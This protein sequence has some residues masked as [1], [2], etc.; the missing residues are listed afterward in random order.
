[1]QTSSSIENLSPK[2]VWG[3]FSEICR[4]PHVSGHE[5]SIGEYLMSVA[6]NLGLEAEMS[7]SGNV[8]I[9]KQ[10]SSGMENSPSVLLQSHMDMVGVKEADLQFNFQKDAIRPVI[11]DDGFV[12]AE[13]T[14]LGADNGIGVAI[15]LAILSD[16]TLRHPKIKALFTVSEETSMGGAN[17][18]TEDDMDCNLA[19]NIDSEDIGE[20][21]IGCAGG[22]AYNISYTPD[23]RAVPDSGF[24]A[25]E[26]RMSN[27]L[28]GHSGIDINKNRLNGGGT[29]LYL[30]SSL[31]EEG[32]NVC[33]STFSSGHVRNSIPSCASATLCLQEHLINKFINSLQDIINRLQTKFSESDPDVSFEITRMDTLPA[34]MM[35]EESTAD[36]LNLKSLNTKIIEYLDD[37][38]T[39][40]TSCN[41]GVARLENNICRF[42]LL[43]RYATD[44]GKAKIEKKIEDIA[45]ACHARIDHKE[46]Y[47][48]W[49]PDFSSSLMKLA[50]DEY[51]KLTGKKTV[52]TVIHA[53]LECG[54]FKALNPKLDIISIGPDIYGAHSTSERVRISSVE[55]CY[56]WIVNIL[57]KL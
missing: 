44:D 30:L 48:F 26:I 2:A 32:F 21:C 29:L 42:E 20:I 55:T 7:G 1:M 18:L 22:T 28:G 41:M 3:Y 27:G 43:A 33:V 4:I 53:G 25:V 15:I 54:L 37:G 51:E 17:A 5:Q 13:G 45:D 23:I 40:L 14:T 31:R 34:V 49:K 9:T 36:F 24:G 6:A 57:E 35:T 50:S 16:D 11:S 12:T 46:S 8:F 19:I 10:A 52:T 47:V 38:V 56:K 39:P